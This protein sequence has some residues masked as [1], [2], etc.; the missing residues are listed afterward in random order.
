MGLRGLGLEADKPQLE[1]LEPHLSHT[2]FS[3]LP[4]IQYVPITLLTGPL[5]LLAVLGVLDSG[6]HL[7]AEPAEPLSPSL[8]ASFTWRPLG[9]SDY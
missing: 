9:L 2:C 8:E 5:N 7:N 4:Y 6:I 1:D 3:P